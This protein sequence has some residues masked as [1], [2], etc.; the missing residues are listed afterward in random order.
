MGV[1]GLL[2]NVPAAPLSA[3]ERALRLARLLALWQS[4]CRRLVD[5]TLCHD[6]AARN[7]E[8]ARR[9]RQRLRHRPR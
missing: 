8:L 5:E 9:V 1:P 2:R 4:G 3:E 6:I 7:P